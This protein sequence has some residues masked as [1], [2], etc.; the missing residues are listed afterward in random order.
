MGSTAIPV[1]VSQKLILSHRASRR[2]GATS[3]YGFQPV[4]RTLEFHDYA[5]TKGS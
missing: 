1:L 4:L 5:S 3:E 2:G